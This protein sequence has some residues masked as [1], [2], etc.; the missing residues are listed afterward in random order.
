[1]LFQDRLLIDPTAEP[2]KKLLEQVG[3][4]CLVCVFENN[5]NMQNYDSLKKELECDMECNW[6]DFLKAVTEFHVSCAFI[7]GGV[8]L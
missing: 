6:L 2:G 8:H 4:L 3:L 5:S 7:S 1:M